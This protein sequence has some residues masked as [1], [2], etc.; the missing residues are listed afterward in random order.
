[1]ELKQRQDDHA[2]CCGSRRNPPSFETPA[3]LHRLAEVMEQEGVKPRTLANRIGTTE[4]TVI[5]KSAPDYDMRL[6]ELYQWQEALNVPVVEL[7][8]EA[9]TT[10]ST[11][12]ELRTRLLK[13]MRSVRSIQEHSRNESVQTL[14]MQLS[15]QLMQM[16]PELKEVSAWPSVGQQRKLN[17]LGAVAQNVVPEQI[18][19]S[20][21]RD[22]G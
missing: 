19:N 5:K 6:S 3:A 8:V 14:A 11:P 20:P 15:E 22:E 7:L 18:L 12:I 10:L 13:L 4:A 16:M 21:Y 1:M 9:E 2:Y 17:E